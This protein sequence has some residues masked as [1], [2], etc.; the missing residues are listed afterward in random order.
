[1]YCEQVSSW[2]AVYG[3]ACGKLRTDVGF[4]EEDVRW[5]VSL[6]RAARGGDESG[7]CK[8]RL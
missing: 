8:L 7:F 6:L 5:H 1:M 4:G 3:C 2:W